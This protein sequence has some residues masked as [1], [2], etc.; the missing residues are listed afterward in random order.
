[1]IWVVG[2]KECK[3][4]L[5]DHDHVVECVE[6]APENALHAVAASGES[7]VKEGRRRRRRRGFRRVRMNERHAFLVFVCRDGKANNPVPF[8]CPAREIRRLGCGMFT[9][10]SACL[11]W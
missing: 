8:S 11:S 7:E 9:G 4:E 5:R 3:T 6:W 1:M 2:T 10:V